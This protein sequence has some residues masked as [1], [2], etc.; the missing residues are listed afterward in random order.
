MEDVD[1]K[2]LSEDIVR[3]TYMRVVWSHKIQEKQADILTDR[4]NRFEFIRVICISLT[5]V[6]LITLLFCDVF[7]VK[8]LS[9]LISFI[10][11]VIAV[12]FKSFNV[13]ENIKKHKHSANELLKIRDQLQL[14]LVKIQ[15]D[16]D[17]KAELLQE[18]ES[19]LKTLWA[20]YDDAPNTSDKAVKNASKALKKN[21]DNEFTDQEIDSNLPESLRRGGK[22][23]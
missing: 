11:T 13:Q 18:Y 22:N 20:V 1:K 9:T 6:G 8:L 12:L 4:Y 10:S 21:K 17:S 15:L 16:V 19:L 14:L 3:Q 23:E 5:S 2:L 7:T